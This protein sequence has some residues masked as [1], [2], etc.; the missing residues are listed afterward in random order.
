MTNIKKPLITIITVSYNAVDSIE[1]TI[2][3]VINQSYLN[4]EYIIIDGN[5]TDGTVD[6]IKKYSD[7]IAY[8]ISEKDKGIYD[9]MNKGIEKATGDYI[10]FLN[11]SDVINENTTIQNIIENLP[12]Q[13][14]DVIYG[15]I[16]IEREDGYYYMHPLELKTF[17]YR[18]PIFH[19]SSWVKT[20]ILKKYKFDTKYKIAADFNFFRFIYYKKFSFYYLPIIFTLFEGINGVSSTNQSKL[21]EEKKEIIKNKCLIIHIINKVFNKLKT[22]KTKYLTK[23]STKQDAKS[24][25]LLDPRIIKIIKKENQ[26]QP[27]CH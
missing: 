11:S 20:E 19:P 22:L 12:N 18:F 7:K 9:A 15:D 4:I 2:L 10:Q 27:I 26:Q 14:T 6:I 5:S 21:E 8:W 3:S 24:K 25:T 17:K 13:N 1:K 23:F 16:I